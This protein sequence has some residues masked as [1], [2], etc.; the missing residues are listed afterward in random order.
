MRVRGN[1]PRGSY[2][3]HRQGI[4]DSRM[5][6][7]AVLRRPMAMWRDGFAVIEEGAE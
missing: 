7:A 4:V 2:C 3:R 5:A 6:G 1:E